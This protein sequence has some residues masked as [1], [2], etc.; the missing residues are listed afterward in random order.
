M[1]GAKDIINGLREAIV[2][3][4]VKMDQ[5]RSASITFNGTCL[6]TVKSDNTGTLTFPLE[7]SR[8]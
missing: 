7:E 8:L 5:V 3:A 2:A 1:S 6:I 4:Q